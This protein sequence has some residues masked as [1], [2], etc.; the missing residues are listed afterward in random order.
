M[1]NDI[2]QVLEFMKNHKFIDAIKFL[3]NII[4]NNQQNV[5]PYN[6]RAICY[7]QLSKYK[8]AKSDFDK[9]LSLKPNVPEVYN[10]LGIL[11]FRLGQNNLAVTNFLKSIEINNNFE[12]AF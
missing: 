2:H 9:V 3:D 4:L 6:L 8:K 5:E 12:E 1:Q 7:L 10:N 11:H